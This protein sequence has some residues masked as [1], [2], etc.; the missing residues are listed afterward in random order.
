MKRSRRFPILLQALFLLLVASHVCYA[1]WDLTAPADP[2][3]YWGVTATEAGVYDDNFFGTKTNVQAGLRFS[4]D[5]KLH[6]SIPLER[7][8][9]G[10]QYDYTIV[11]PH[12]INQGGV[13]QTHNVSV[14]A[15]YIV[16]PRLELSLS[17][18]YVSSLQPGLV[19][20]N[21]VPATISN[22]GDYIYDAVGGGVNYVLAPR[23]T[24]AVNG[25]WD[26]WRY[27]SSVTASNNDHE[28]YVMT[29][30]ALYALD[31]RTTVGLNYQYGQNI[32]INPGT[33]NALNAQSHTVYVSVVRRFNPRLSLTLNGGYTVRE[34]EDGSTS[35]SPSGLGSLV[36]NYG[37]LSS[38]SLTIAQ[39]L[40]EASLGITRSFSAQENTSVALQINHRLTT[41]LRVV[42]DASYVYSAFT[43]ALA[44]STVTTSPGQVSPNEQSISGHLGF[45]YAFRDWLSA[46]LDYSHTELITSDQRIITPYT[47]NQVS[48]GVSLTY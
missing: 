12:D 30:S 29:L 11:Y 9:L 27:Q 23:W 34:S 38:A 1:G 47:R 40:T 4:S 26:I 46:V 16:S 21:G 10:M 17:E 35:S 36:Y 5:L 7:L 8:F 2:N 32:F 22:E 20:V 44:G 45:N 6:A 28:D 48:L 19:T 14:S 18:N 13:D 39:S 41:R 31:S 24:L 37:P 42:I 33:N 3:R 25:S 43:Q 15:N